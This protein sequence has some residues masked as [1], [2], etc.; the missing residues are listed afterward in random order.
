[1]NQASQDKTLEN[2]RSLQP[3]KYLHCPSQTFAAS[4]CGPISQSAQRVEVKYILMS[5]HVLQNVNKG[6]L[7]HVN[8]KCKKSSVESTQLKVKMGGGKHAEE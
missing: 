3:Q 8:S 2:A 7:I 6:E 5:L 1:M 4:A